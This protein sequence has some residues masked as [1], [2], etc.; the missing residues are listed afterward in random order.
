MNIYE[1][2]KCKTCGANLRFDIVKQ[3]MKCEHCGNLYPVD[4]IDYQKGNSLQDE[5]ATEQ[6]NSVRLYQCNSCGGEIV[7]L[8]TQLSSRCPYCGQYT[9]S[10]TRMAEDTMPEYI[11]PFKVTREEAVAILRGR[12]NSS[13]F[14]PS[15]IKHFSIEHMQGV[16]LPFGVYH[17]GMDA[18]VSYCGDEQNPNNGL[19]YRKQ[20]YRHLYCEYDPIYVYA[21]NHI[22]NTNVEMLSD[23]DQTG[24]VPFHP[25]YL[26]GFV[27]DCRTMTD[28]EMIESGRRIG[29]NLIL[30][31]IEE[32]SVS[33]PMEDVKG[34]Y[35]LKDERI[36][37][38]LLPAWIITFQHKKKHYSMI[39]NGESA[40][41]L[42]TVPYSDY[43]KD[44]VTFLLFLFFAVVF[45]I[46]S[47]AS[48][49]LVNWSEPK[50]GIFFWPIMFFVDSMCAIVFG[51]FASTKANIF[52][53][54]KKV[55]EQNEINQYTKEREMK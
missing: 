23:Y 26:S 33:P 20:Y 3:K 37:Y 12:L 25:G 19:T 52:K 9:V 18:R 48:F 42:G 32:R 40:S 15:K 16:Y 45:L 4:S 44:I 54:L 28:A 8:D 31:A 51:I 11:I 35:E 39:V 29:A 14:I 50:A 10:F 21:S 5:D 13:F 53:A 30:K 17:V 41:L 27:A 55:T 38:A 2:L 6:K 46:P 36:S 47:I 1:S 7:S 22:K 24:L 43:K 34:K 49:V